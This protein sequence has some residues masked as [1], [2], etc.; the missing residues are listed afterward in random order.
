MGVLH[1]QQHAAKGPPIRDVDIGE[2]FVLIVRERPKAK[3]AERF[4]A[5]VRYKR[6]PV[7]GQYV[8]KFVYG[9]SVDEAE[10]RLVEALLD[11]QK[12]AH[13]LATLNPRY[14]EAPR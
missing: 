12:V 5:T 14:I 9:K 11:D 10:F 4:V 13:L 3:A 7:K 6:P 8:Y 1:W 2:N